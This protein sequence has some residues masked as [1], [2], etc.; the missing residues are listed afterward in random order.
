M[1]PQQPDGPEFP[2]L[3][4]SSS[5]G[6]TYHPLPYHQN[7]PTDPALSED[8]EPLRVG[9]FASGEGSFSPASLRGLR[10]H[11]LTRDND[12]SQ[13]RPPRPHPAAS[14]NLADEAPTGE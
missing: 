6:I 7:P 12:G 3:Q 2:P 13:W 4:I 8:S 9:Y 14:V 5:S 1:P 10:V 11:S